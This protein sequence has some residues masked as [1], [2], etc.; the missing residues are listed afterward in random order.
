MCTK[1]DMS[2]ITHK[3][4]QG[5]TLSPPGK[6]NSSLGVRTVPPLTHLTF[7]QMF[8]DD[9]CLYSP[10]AIFISAVDT[11]VS[12]PLEEEL[13]RNQQDEGKRLGGHQGTAVLGK[14]YF[15]NF[16]QPCC[17]SWQEDHAVL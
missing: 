7:V 13:F 16:F 17:Y 11:Q 10:P 12:E 9:I 3:S 5:P 1:T 15:T 4:R 2:E 8:H 14:K 6:D